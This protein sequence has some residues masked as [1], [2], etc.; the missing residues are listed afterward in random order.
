MEQIFKAF[1]EYPF[2]SDEK[3][4]KGVQSIGK[5]SLET[6]HYFYDKFL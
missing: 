5:D 1:E 6:R 2:E 3:Y 4:Q